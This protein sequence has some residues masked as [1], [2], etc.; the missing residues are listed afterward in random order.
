M[1]NVTRLLCGTPAE[2]DGLRYGQRPPEHSHAP[3]PQ[4]VIHHRPVVVWT[5]TRR[6]NLHCVH[7]YAD[8]KDRPY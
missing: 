1:L 2:G 3:G 6:C 7:C 5:A 4:K 8:S